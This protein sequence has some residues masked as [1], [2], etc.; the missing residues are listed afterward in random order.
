MLG[1]P[2]GRGLNYW[3]VLK[4]STTLTNLVSTRAE[5]CENQEKTE[6]ADNWLKKKKKAIW[7]WY[8]QVHCLRGGGVPGLDL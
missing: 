2:F 3:G 8:C 7:V 1:T 5:L 4:L 6:I